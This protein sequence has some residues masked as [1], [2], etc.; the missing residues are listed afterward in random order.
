MFGELP[1]WGFYVRHVEGLKMKNIRLECVESDFRPALVFDN[2]QGL[3][4]NNI[5]IV[6]SGDIPELVLRKTTGVIEKRV[7]AKKLVLKK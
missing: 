7:R 4:L 6:K 3:N 1:A 5:R 2:V